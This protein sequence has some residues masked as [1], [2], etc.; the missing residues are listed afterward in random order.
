MNARTTTWVVRTYD[1]NDADDEDREM[2]KIKLWRKWVG[3]KDDSLNQN[4]SER[5]R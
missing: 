2:K 4:R 1:A 5:N 3:S